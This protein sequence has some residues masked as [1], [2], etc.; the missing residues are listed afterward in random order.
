MTRLLTGLAI[1]V[2]LVPSLLVAHHS[3]AAEF[4]SSKPVTVK[5]AVTKVEWTNPHIWIYVD[6]KEESSAVVAKWQ[7]EMGSPNSLMRL[8]WRADS[9]KQGDQVT[10]DGTRAKDGSNTCN[11]RTVRMAD[12]RRMFAGSSEGVAPTRP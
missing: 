11:A 12:G 10:I 1:A 8:G 3:F 9:L 4:D 2:L 6:Q 5:G 7:C